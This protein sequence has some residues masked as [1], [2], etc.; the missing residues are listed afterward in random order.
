METGDI[1]LLL[2]QWRQGDREALDRIAPLVYEHLRRLAGHYMSN[3]RSNHTLQPTELVSELFV[4]LLRLKHVAIEDRNHFFAL[5][6][7]VMRQILVQYA[8]KLSAERRGGQSIR[9]IPLNVELE[10]VGIGEGPAMTLDLDTALDDLERLDEV[11]VRA[12]ELRYFFGFTT[13]E[14]ARVL[15]QSVSTVERKIRFSLA[16]LSD[17]LHPET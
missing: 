2:Y 8:R 14:T 15:E 6:A 17:R 9:L 5:S 12:I 13:P 10:W 4:E 16:W 11:A 3:E 1:T 7:R